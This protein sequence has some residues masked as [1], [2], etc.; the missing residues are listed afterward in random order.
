MN[1]LIVYLVVGENMKKLLNTVLKSEMQ[2][3]RMFEGL[4]KKKAATGIV[5]K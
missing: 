3:R 2:R 1:E 5:L 4:M